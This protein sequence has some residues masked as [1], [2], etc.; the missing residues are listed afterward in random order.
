MSHRE[1]GTDKRTQIEFEIIS[2]PV[3]IC[4]YELS[5]HVLGFARYVTKLFQLEKLSDIAGKT[6]HMPA[7]FINADGN[8]V[9]D[10]FKF[11][12]RPLIGSG[13]PVAHRLRAPRV[14]KL[15]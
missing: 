3:A 6:K 15:L 5:G 12:L 1:A 9:T 10:D 2:N 4:V 14:S 11:Y 8:G 7:E 13:F